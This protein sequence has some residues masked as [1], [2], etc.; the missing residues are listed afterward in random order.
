MSG[1][2]LGNHSTAE[3]IKQKL[4]AKVVE[5]CYVRQEHGEDIVMERCLIDNKYD[6][7]YRFV[8]VHDN[9][10]TVIIT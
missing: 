10:K 4:N 6:N 9:K 7:K 5:V 2:E 1:N 8:I 3:Y